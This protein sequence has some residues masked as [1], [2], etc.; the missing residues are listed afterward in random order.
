MRSCDMPSALFLAYLSEVSRCR[1]SA[2]LR[3]EAEWSRRGGRE[4]DAAEDDE[5]EAGELA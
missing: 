4:V 1:S 5:A 3:G 2:P